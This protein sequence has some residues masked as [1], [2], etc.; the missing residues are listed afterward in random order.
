MVRAPTITMSVNLFGLII[1]EARQSPIYSLKCIAFLTFL[2]IDLSTR[3]LYIGNLFHMYGAHVILTKSFLSFAQRNIG[4]I[5]NR[6]N[7][8]GYE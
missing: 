7:Y 3:H 8:H 2:I 5:D 4:D 6:V 1:L